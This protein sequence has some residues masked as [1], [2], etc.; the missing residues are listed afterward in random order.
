MAFFFVYKYKGGETKNIPLLGGGVSG[1]K[2][3]VG[4]MGVEAGFGY[5][6]RLLSFGK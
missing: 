5:G 1:A 6:H 4:A 3:R 2:F